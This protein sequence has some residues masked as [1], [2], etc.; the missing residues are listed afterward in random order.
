MKIKTI[1]AP[2][3]IKLQV[4]IMVE[5]RVTEEIPSINKKELI[6]TTII[7]IVHL[8]FLT[9]FPTKCKMILKNK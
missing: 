8:Q 6:L 7:I 3:V 9:I 5:N 4:I 2:M 1:V